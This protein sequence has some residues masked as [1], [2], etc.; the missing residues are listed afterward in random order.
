MSSPRVTF[1]VHLDRDLVARI[2]AQKTKSRH[3]AVVELLEIGL[4]HVE[5]HAAAR[6]RVVLDVFTMI[7]GELKAWAS[8][9]SE[10]SGEQS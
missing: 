10:I 3:S 2:D 9:A 7:E 4:A 1:S 5:G 6:R 8:R